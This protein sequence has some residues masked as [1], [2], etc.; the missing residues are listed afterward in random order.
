MLRCRAHSFPRVCPLVYPVWATGAGIFCAA[1]LT[2]LVALKASSRRAG[3][4]MGCGQE[5][6]RVLHHMPFV[7]VYLE[8]YGCQM[9]VNDTE[10]VW[11]I[12]QKNGYA[13]TKKLDEADVVLLVTCSVR[14][15]AE[16]A[17]WNRLQHLR[18]LKARRRPARAALRIGILG[19]AAL[20]HLCPTAA[21]AFPGLR[22]A[23][24]GCRRVTGAGTAPSAPSPS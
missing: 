22:A 12:L 5:L 7:A 23:G 1:F 14:E 17:I 24:K 11:A 18:A 2:P 19:R 15:K 16:Q 21:P 13:R 20:H 3:D 10:I 9:N 4:R 6:D 8:T